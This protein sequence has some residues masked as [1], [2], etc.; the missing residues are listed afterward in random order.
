VIRQLRKTDIPRLKEL[1]NGFTWEFDGDFIEGLAAVDEHDS[2]V[3][4]V[5]AWRRAEVH[6][7]V[8]PKW[9]TPGA[10]FLQLKELHE[11]MRVELKAKG[12]SQAVTWFEDV[13]DRFVERLQTWGWVK[14]QL[15]S[16]H[17]EL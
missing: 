3:M 5:G 4:F 16:W 7:A 17:K 2:P 10:R 13:K 12:F 9:S 15:T 6:I 8:D 11:A 14:S 1:E